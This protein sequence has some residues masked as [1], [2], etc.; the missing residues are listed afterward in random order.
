MRR[1]V[2]IAILA[3]L[4]L[5]AP[6]Q[7]AVLV[8]APPKRLVCGDAITVGIWAQSWTTGSRWVRMKAIDRA[9]GTVWWHRKARASKRHWRYWGLPSGMD[10]QCGRTT[11]VYRGHGF[12][13]TFHVR[14]KS[15]GV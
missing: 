7:A 11:I 5:A 14:F 4:A 12:K 8:H 3:T 6:A 15:E 1:T 9:T 10:G 2:P 13:A